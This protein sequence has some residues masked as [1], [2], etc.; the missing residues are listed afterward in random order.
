MLIRIIIVILILLA[1]DLYGYYGLKK[2]LRFHPFIGYKKIITRSY[3]FM[4]LGFIVFS[5]TWIV[6]IRNS[7]WPDYIQYRNYFYI[8]GAFL[9]IFLPKLLFL[10]F[11]VLNDIMIFVRWLVRSIQEKPVL[12]RTFP[13]LLTTG[14]VFSVL[15][16]SW[17][18]YGIVYGR[19]NFQVKKVEVVIDNLPEAFHGF[20]IMH[21]SDAHLGSFARKRPVERALQ[22]M[23]DT[24]HDILVFTGDMVNNEAI[25][26]ERFISGFNLIGSPYGMYS[27]LGNH[28]MGDYRRWYTIDEKEAN[29][30]L[31]EDYQKKMGFSLLRNEH[32]FVVRG[33]DSLM[34]AGI[35]NWGVPPFAQYGDL[36]KALGDFANFPHII[37]LSH[38]PSHWHAEVIPQTDIIL[39]LSGH[40]H[41][42][43]A[44][45]NTP[46]FR[47]SPVAA[48]YPE[49]S[50]LYRDNRQ[51]LYV[52]KGLGYL[53]FPGRLGM[54]PEITL[55]QLV[56]GN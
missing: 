18:A 16:F 51:M 32:H 45:I 56:K 7:N 6:I 15:M 44:G 17:V 50:G 35:D 3:W 46:W 38:D 13:V 12:N 36:E 54:R 1:I 53:G 5:I 52:N 43:Q 42:M 49:W 28:D 33:E 19:F 2:L 23:R 8:T 25:E 10:I 48:R 55:L 29:L 21:I 31:L 9:L 37:L 20:R 41:A 11:V 4:D 40:T 39:T 27:V 24:P 47:W 30:E 26:V 22:M 34:I 14:F